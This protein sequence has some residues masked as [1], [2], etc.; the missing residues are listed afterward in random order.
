M[1]RTIKM[2]SL[3]PI[4]SDSLGFFIVGQNLQGVGEVQFYSIELDNWY[5]VLLNGQTIQYELHSSGFPA[6]K[7]FKTTNKH[8][9][10]LLIAGGYDPV[11]HSVSKSVKL[12]KV[13]L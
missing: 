5:P 1:D 12:Y 2:G 11:S 9:G 3:A 13:Y 6:T 4:H 8:L 7:Y 10:Y